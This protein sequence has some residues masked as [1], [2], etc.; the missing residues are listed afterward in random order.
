MVN[1]PLLTVLQTNFLFIILLIGISIGIYSNSL[2]NDFAVV[3]D[4]HG[5]IENEKIR[6][7]SESFKTLHIQNMVYSLNYKF[8]GINPLPLRILTL[9]NHAVASVFIF[10]IIY[11]L[12]DFKTAAIAA[13]LFAVHPVNTETINWVSAQFYTL[14]ANFQFATIL[15]YLAYRQTHRNKYIYGSVAII[16]LYFLLFQHPWVLTIPLIM[17]V[18]DFIANKGSFDFTFH[19]KF[20][21]LLGPIILIYLLLWF[22]QSYTDRMATQRVE[23][24][25]ILLNEQALIP[26]IEGYPYTIANMLRLYTFPKDL[27]IYYDGNT[28]TSLDRLFMFAVFLLYLAGIIYTYHSNKKIAVLLVLL[29]VCIAPVF[30]PIKVTWY[31]TERYLYFGTG[32]FTTLLALLF[33]YIEKKTSIKYIS[34]A[35][36][37]LIFILFSIRTTKRTTDWKNP[38]TLAFATMQ[39][40]PR[41]VRPYNDV[42]GHYTL[43]G[44][45]AQAKLYY[46]KALTLYPSSV[47]MYN[48]GYLYKLHDLD[49]AV[50]TLKQPPEEILTLGN[51]AMQNKEYRLA[52]YY[53]NEIYVPDTKD[54]NLLNSISAAFLEVGSY[55][56]AEKYLTKSLSLDP[57]KADTIFLFGYLAYKKNDIPKALKYLDAVLEIEPTH[58]GALTN[59]E[60]IQSNEYTTIP[61]IPPQLPEQK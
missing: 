24:G 32:F 38:E 43:T 59:K 17:F 49:P 34:V 42:A 1:K 7:I 48:L 37:I 45:T 55:D 35:L 26:I 39:T 22:P 8:F 11:Q 21:I 44:R 31:I 13:L 46:Q 2:Q 58:A 6:N 36:T 28:L 53:F 61:S 16:F 27:T 18:I 5:Y 9:L 51:Q 60:H 52:L 25:K 57:A 41:S 30:S 29:A 19:K 4:L 14:M 10:L 47:A 12:F 15:S 50:R 56:Y 40:S 23:A 3:D 33:I 54:I 20:W